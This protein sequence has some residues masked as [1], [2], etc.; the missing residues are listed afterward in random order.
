[1][2]H[3]RERVRVHDVLGVVLRHHRPGPEGP[4]TCRTPPQS[5]LPPLEQSN[6][7]EYERTRVERRSLEHR[8]S[9]RLLYSLFDNQRVSAASSSQLSVLINWGSTRWRHFRLH[10]APHAAYASLGK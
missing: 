5:A 7:E 4:I 1:M 6:G 2:Q 10:G 8:T 3:M 9:V